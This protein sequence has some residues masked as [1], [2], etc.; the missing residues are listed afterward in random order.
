MTGSG[1]SGRNRPGHLLTLSL[2]LN[3]LLVG[4]G[5]YRLLDFDGDG[6]PR[7]AWLPYA[8][9]TLFAELPPVDGGDIH[10]GASIIQYGAWGELL[11]PRVA[12]NRGIAGDTTAGVLARLDASVRG[13][14]ERIFVMVGLNDLFT[15]VPEAEVEANMRQILSGLAERAPEAEVFVYSLLPV[16][17]R[18]PEAVDVIRRLNA[19]VQELTVAAGHRFVDLQPAFADAEG[20]LKAELTTDGIH[21]D[22][23]G[24]RLWATVLGNEGLN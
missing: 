16:R 11:A 9:T 7:S 3:V 4:Y 13:S 1:G 17:G 5:A 12:H 6:P 22:G 20:Q 10:L 24:Y 18:G 23:A 8:R 14:P 19:R 15:G 2:L 21:L